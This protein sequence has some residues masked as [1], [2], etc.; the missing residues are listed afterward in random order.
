M[1]NKFKIFL[2]AASK[3]L[4]YTGFYHVFG[5][6]VISKI[7]SFAGGILLVHIISKAEY[8]VYTYANNIYGFFY[9]LSGMGM[10]SAVL[11]LCSESGDAERRMDIY[12]YGSSFGTKVNLLLSFTILATAAF[13]KLPIKGANAMLAALSLLPLFSFSLDIRSTWLRAELKNREYAYTN[14]IYAIATFLFSVSFSLLF[15]AYGPI[16][17][18]YFSAAIAIIFAS[19]YS[20]LSQSTT[21]TAMSKDDRKALLSL[22]SVTL[23]NNGLSSLMYLLDIFVIG[24]FIP[25]ETV[26]ASYKVATTIPSALQFIPSSIIIYAYPYFARHKNDKRWTIG[27]YKLL[28]LGSG[29]VNFFIAV[30]LIIFSGFVVPLIFGEQYADAV[31]CFVILCISFAFSGTFR[32]MAGN[33]LFTQ[34][35]LKYNLFVAAFSSSFNTVMNVLLVL[36]WGSIGAAVATLLT[37]LLTSALSTGYLIYVYKKLPENA[38]AES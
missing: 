33:L 35:K 32:I 22:G 21:H 10:S 34:R 23:L 24:L 12:R 13:V 9:L 18:G 1:V 15:G 26:I 30:V 6:S 38:G 2:T 7:F 5:S 27:K 11:Q 3:K 31:P 37:A 8:G 14:S 29:A 4:K 16:I 20:K 17:S 36:H 25:D 28:T 19:R